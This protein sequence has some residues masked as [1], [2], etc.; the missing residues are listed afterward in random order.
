M[1]RL[2]IYPDH[3]P[4]PLCQTDDA[5]A[6]AAGLAEIGVR[7]ERWDLPVHPA[8]DAPDQAILAA[9][10]PYLDTLIGGSAGSADVLRVA[11][12]D[13]R[14]PAMRR[15]FLGEHTHDEHEIRFFVH[16][17]ANFILH[18]HGRVYD[19]QCRAGDLISVP[20]GIPHWFDAGDAPDFTALRVF[21]DAAGWV[22]H[23]TGD[24]I[25]ERY[26]ACR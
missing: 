17:G 2:T 9:Y 4:T 6:I 24:R 22:P 5:A 15:I 18:H 7:F 1:S 25:S 21:T 13:P 3:S 23:Y 16:G 20:A 8:P 10:R 11:A 12:G 19:A 26:P 14:Y